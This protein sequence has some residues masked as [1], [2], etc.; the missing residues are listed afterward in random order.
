MAM[1][2]TSG[3][4][5]ESRASP[6][7]DVRARVLAEHSRLRIII[8]EV[9]RYAIAVAAGEEQLVEK[10]RQE[11][12][13]LYHL[14]TKHIDHEDAVLA[15]LIRRIDAWGIVRFEQMQRDHEGQREALA[16]AVRDLETQGRSLGQ[17]VQSMLWEILHDM[18]REEHDLLHP[19]LWREDLTVVEI[20]G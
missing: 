10:L 6:V 16:R 17:G 11:A 8:A 20:G 13:K 9:D 2:P 4:A 3:D 14:L 1:E 5:K 15:P 18:K 12:E 19:D 7:G